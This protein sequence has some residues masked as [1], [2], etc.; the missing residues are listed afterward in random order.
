MA[1][2]ARRRSH[3]RTSAQQYEESRGT[4]WARVIES[5]DSLGAEASANGLTNAKLEALLADES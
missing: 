5:M 4:G 3:G 2:S 1:H